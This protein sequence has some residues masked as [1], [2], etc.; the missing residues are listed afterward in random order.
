MIELSQRIQN[1]LTILCT[2]LYAAQQQD[3]VVRAAADLLCQDLTMKLTGSRPTDAYFR[4]A[5][6]LG[7]QIAG[8]GFTSLSGIDAGEI[9]MPY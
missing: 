1:L 7:E 6:Q 5:N 2:T 4:A 9:L 8:G 3:E